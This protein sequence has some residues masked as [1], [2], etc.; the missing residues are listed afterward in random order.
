MTIAP[1]GED[2]PSQ[3]SPCPV[4][5][6]QRPLREFRQLSASWFFAWPVGGM[7]SLV[8]P[9]ALA[10]ALALPPCLLVASGSYILRHQLPRLLLAGALAALALP[11]LLLVRQWLGWTYVRSRLMAE[12][13]VYEESG[14]YDGQVWEKPLLWSQQDRLVA[15]H[16]VNPV[17]QRLR[18]ASLS[19]LAALLAGAGLWQAL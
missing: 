4:P 12:R 10:W 11:L 17:L 8:R 14:W 1:T 3:D 5:P 15:R 19:L 16:E 6:E 7:A 9:L 18:S 13:V 2:L